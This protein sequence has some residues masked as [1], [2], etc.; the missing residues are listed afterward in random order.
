[1]PSRLRHARDRAREWPCVLKF[2][3]KPGLTRELKLV[4]VKVEFDSLASR[5]KSPIQT[6][7]LGSGYSVTLS[8]TGGI[9]AR[10][11]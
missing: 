1:M 8:V 3:G 7:R 4:Y 10:Q 9:Q 5:A 2:L 11:T 6:G